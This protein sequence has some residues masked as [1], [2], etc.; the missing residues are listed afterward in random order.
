MH[1]LFTILIPPFLHWRDS[2]HYAVT[3][4]PMG[5]L[6]ISFRERKRRK[7]QSIAEN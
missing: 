3:L 1:C 6:T 5:K 2:Y 4:S 7:T